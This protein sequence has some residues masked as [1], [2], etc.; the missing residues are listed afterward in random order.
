MRRSRRL[1]RADFDRPTLKVARDLLGK[2][3]VRVHRGRRR[4]AMISE[5]EAYKGPADLAAH[6]AGGR[7]TARV[8]PLYGHGG[9][10]YVY[11]CY[12]IH[13]LLNFST[14]GHGKPE[15]VLIRG[16]LAGPEGAEKP[17]VG[18][19]NVTRHLG[20]DKALYGADATRSSEIWIE[21]RGVKIPAHRVRTGPRV[22]VDYAGPHWAAKPW[23]FRIALGPVAKGTGD[24]AQGTRRKKRG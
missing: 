22:G 4:A 16:V 2:Y 11:L 14:A 20:I 15:G 19:G 10:V 5:V 12:G 8:E 23:R 9:T 1:G 6:T 17:V 24:K 3:I 18:P 13:W 7:R 21:D